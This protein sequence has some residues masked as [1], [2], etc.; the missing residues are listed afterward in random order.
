[1]NPTPWYILLYFIY[2]IVILWKVQLI[3][4]QQVQFSP[5]TASFVANISLIAD[6]NL[7]HYLQQLGWI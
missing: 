6:K 5:L 3:V 1:M 2:G 4:Q 7:V